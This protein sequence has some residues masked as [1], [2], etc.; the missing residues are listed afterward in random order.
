MLDDVSERTPFSFRPFRNLYKSSLRKQVRAVQRM[1][2]GRV[3]LHHSISCPGSRCLDT[4]ASE[5]I[6]ILR[7]PWPDIKRTWDP[8]D[9]TVRL[10]LI[11]Q[12]H[13]VSKMVK[14]FTCSSHENPKNGRISRKSCSLSKNSARTRIV[15]NLCKQTVSIRNPPVSTGN[16]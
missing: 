5:R 9:S 7:L 2:Y 11:Q 3:A 16:V 14:R 1:P 12:A 10:R 8:L 15:V 13:S 6:L 4:D